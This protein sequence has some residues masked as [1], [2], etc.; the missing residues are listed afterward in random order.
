MRVPKLAFAF[1]FTS[2]ASVAA[3]QDP[4]P[5]AMQMQVQKIA[6]ERPREAEAAAR[7]FMFLIA[8]DRVEGPRSLDSLKAR[9]LDQYWMEV[10]QLTVQFD[11]V[12]ILIRRDSVRAQLVTKMFGIESS[13]RELQRAYR[14]ASESQRATLR[15]QLEALIGGHFDIEN[16]LRVLEMKDIERRLADVRTETQRR[17]DKRVELVKW[18]VDDI[19]RDATRPQ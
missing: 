6:Q 8:P 13:A 9:S 10:A 4:N 5:Q 16:Q 7:A 15:T 17:I 19:I 14:G 3:A 1:V 11:M 2:L 12:Q 18:A